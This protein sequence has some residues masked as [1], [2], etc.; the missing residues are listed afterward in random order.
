MNETLKRRIDQEV[1]RFSTFELEPI[2]VGE[3]FK[4]FSLTNP[5]DKTSYRTRILFDGDQK[6]FIYGDAYVGAA[7]LC[8]TAVVSVEWRYGYSWFSK[9]MDFD[10]LCQ[11]FYQQAWS[12]EASMDSLRNA[13][14][15]E[16][17]DEWD[18]EMKDSLRQLLACSGD[19]EDADSGVEFVE[20]AMRVCN[21]PSG[22]DS[23]LWERH[24][25]ND[26]PLVPASLLYGIHLR[27]V[28]A[29][30]EWAMGRDTVVDQS[31]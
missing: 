8:N 17:R 2:E 11:K 26:F 13:L 15:G 25:H 10:Y 9:K 24:C 18:L 4:A 20:T 5:N 31:L 14:R 16:D 7:P 27:F 21:N 29:H 30:E 19:L 1:A 6:T 22:L 3:R 28:E 23:Y 12:L